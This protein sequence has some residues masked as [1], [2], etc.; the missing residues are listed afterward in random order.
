MKY[1]TFVEKYRKGMILTFQI[2]VACCA[3]IGAVLSLLLA[4]I[5]VNELGLPITGF[6]ILF[7]GWVYVFNFIVYGW[8][9]YLLLFY[10][11]QIYEQIKLKRKKK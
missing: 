4:M 1:N 9:L 2:F 6:Q 10:G 3:M 8:M 5:Y 7:K 11:K